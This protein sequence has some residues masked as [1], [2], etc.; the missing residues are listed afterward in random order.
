MEKVNPACKIYIEY[1]MFEETSKPKPK[2]YNV[3]VKICIYECKCISNISD[4][5]FPVPYTFNIYPR[6]SSYRINFQR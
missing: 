5:Q 1:N 2:N 3:C 4:F 6:S